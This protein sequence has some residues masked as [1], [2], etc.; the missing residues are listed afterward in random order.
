MRTSRFILRI[1]ILWI[2]FIATERPIIAQES[3]PAEEKAVTCT[4]ENPLDGSMWMGTNGDG[5]YRLGKNGSR[6]HFGA[7][8]GKLSSDSILYICFD[9]RGK[10]WIIGADGSITSYNSKE[11]FK[12]IAAIEE[13]ISGAIY[14][15]KE[16][17]IL[18]ASVTK[19]VAFDALTEKIESESDIPFT[20]KNLKLSSDSSSVWI[21]GEKE[22]AKYDGAGEGLK[23]EGVGEV[24]NSIPLEF[25]TYTDTNASRGGYLWI[26]L[27]C[28]LG[29]ALIVVFIIMRKSP[30]RSGMT[31]RNSGTTS[32]EP[33]ITSEDSRHIIDPLEVTEEEVKAAEEIVPEPEPVQPEKKAEPVTKSEP[34]FEPKSSGFTSQVMLLISEHYQE[35]DFDVD[36]IAALTGMSRIHVNRKLKAEGSPSPSVLIKE[37]RMDAAKFLLLESTMPM[38]QIASECGFRTPSYFT[39]AFKEYTGLTPSEYIAQNRL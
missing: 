11:G 34:K 33:E 14:L 18:I 25:E 20:P 29:L 13:E 15:P 23:W 35:P 31:G 27:T 26:I 12:K 28:A 9:S 30:I 10:L 38:A 7:K 17:K 37:K 5:L 39:T 16:N 24:S 3:I 2:A 1:T 8:S 22:V 4:A 6:L 21:F 36:A 19:F 32:G